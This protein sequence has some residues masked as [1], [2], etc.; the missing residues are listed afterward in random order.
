MNN[1]WGASAGFNKQ[2]DAVARKVKKLLCHAVNLI[3]QAIAK[4]MV[5][6]TVGQL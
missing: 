6:L 4:W 5:Q 3:V 1:V 2:R